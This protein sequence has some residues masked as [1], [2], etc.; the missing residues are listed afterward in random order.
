MIKIDTK[1]PLS[2]ER[3]PV[4]SI[5]GVE[6]SMPKEING[7]FAIEVLEQIR[8]NGAE[9]VVSF[10]LEEAIGS[11]GYRALRGCETLT[12]ADLKAVISIVQDH[13][14]GAVEEVAGK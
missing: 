4:F 11:K 7:H 12:T 3:I 6:Y 2:D 9:S 8:S 14:L 5:D 1:T 10:M 13:V